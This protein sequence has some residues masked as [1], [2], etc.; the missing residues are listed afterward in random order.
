MKKLQLVILMILSALDTSIL[1][2]TLTMFC[3]L[4]HW[5]S[6]FEKELSL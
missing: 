2:I 4:G 5:K 6:S 1:F 3:L